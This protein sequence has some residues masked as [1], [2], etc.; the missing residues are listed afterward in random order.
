MATWVGRGILLVA[1]IATVAA[2]CSTF[3]S[4]SGEPDAAAPMPPSDAA[5][6]D[7]ATTDAPQGVDAADAG[8]VVPDPD[9]ACRERDAGYAIANCTDAG[10][11]SVSCGSQVCQDGTPIC[12]RGD[13]GGTPADCR[14]SC[15]SDTV[16][17]ECD[18]PDDCGEGQVCCGL[19][20]SA[21]I[22][23]VC[24]KECGPLPYLALC[25]SS[26]HCRN[27]SCT[28]AYSNTGYRYCTN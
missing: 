8:V 27:G 13:G 28:T 4:S 22:R 19:A 10:V 5:V 21:G 12:C 17:L 20:M 18:S 15:T 11:H 26:L 16:F 9:A 1:V 7:Q 23:A 6:Q 2:A 25:T 3:S 24:A 14:A